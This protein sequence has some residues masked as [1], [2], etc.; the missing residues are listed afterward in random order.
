MEDYGRAFCIL[1]QRNFFVWMLANFSVSVVACMAVE[2]WYAL[3]HPHKYKIF[4][5]VRKTLMYAAVSCGTILLIVIPVFYDATDVKP[6]GSKM[7]CFGKPVFGKMLTNQI[8]VIFYCTATSF[9]PFLVITFSYLHIRFSV[10]SHRQS[11]V[12]NAQRSR[13]QLEVNLSRMSAVT[14]LVLAFFLFPSKI[15]YVLFMFDLTTW[16]MVHRMATLGVL[17]SVVNPWIYC[18]TNKVYRRAFAELF[19]CC[20]KREKVT[21]RGSVHSRSGISHVTSLRS[22]QVLPTIELE[23]AKQF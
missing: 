2:R 23:F 19:C 15:A 17:N 10:I 13:Q 8:Y 3:V 16:D 12:T 18:L 22:S 20:K 4:F 5:S 9:I 1:L 11:P 7:I 21:L 14:A 6:K